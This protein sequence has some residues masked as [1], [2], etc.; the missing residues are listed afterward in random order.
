[1]R[2]HEEN[3]LLIHNIIIVKICSSKELLQFVVLKRTS[4]HFI[5]KK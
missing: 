3:W 1:M 2:L 4:D 5:D